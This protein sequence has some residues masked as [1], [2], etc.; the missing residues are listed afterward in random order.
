MATMI[1]PRIVFFAL[2]LCFAPL[3]ARGAEPPPPALTPEQTWALQSFL[4]SFAEDIR[5][6]IVERVMAHAD[7]S[8]G[9]T[10]LDAWRKG[11]AAEFKGYRYLEARF[12]P[13]PWP[14][15]EADGVLAV[16]PVLRCTYAPA[17]GEPLRNDPGTTQPFRLRWDGHRFHV[18]GSEWLDSLPPQNEKTFFPLL[19]RWGAIILLGLFFWVAS[20]LYVAERTH[21][22]KAATFV[23]L[24]PVAGAAIYFAAVLLRRRMR[25]RRWRR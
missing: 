18:L 12:E 7:P 21:S 4:D 16:R 1:H 15:W 23:F 6:G 19:F 17:D 2:L 9:R 8:V 25:K 10:D 5:A 3:P 13:D 22:L 14:E 11:L 20:T 24:L